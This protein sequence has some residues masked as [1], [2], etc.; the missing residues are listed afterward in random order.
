M[1]VVMYYYKTRMISRLAYANKRVILL[2][3][4]L[5]TLHIRDRPRFYDQFGHQTANASIGNKY[6]FTR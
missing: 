3:S 6:F 4:I 5:H 1:A 2:L